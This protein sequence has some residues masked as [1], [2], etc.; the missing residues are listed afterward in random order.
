MPGVQEVAWTQAATGSGARL[1][2]LA[3]PAAGCFAEYDSA[4]A[5]ALAA[6]KRAIDASLG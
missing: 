1:P 3:S 5:Y 6:A 2:K 4:A